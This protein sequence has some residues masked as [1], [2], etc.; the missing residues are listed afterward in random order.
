VVTLSVQFLEY[1]E[2]GDINILEKLRLVN[3][4]VPTLFYNTEQDHFSTHAETI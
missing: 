2:E 3:V 4:H 1:L